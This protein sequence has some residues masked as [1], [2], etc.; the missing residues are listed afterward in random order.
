MN[1]K[2][3]KKYEFI[4]K[5]YLLYI[6]MNLENNQAY[7]AVKENLEFD[8]NKL[9]SELKRKKEALEALNKAKA[10]NRRIPT[11]EYKQ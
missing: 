3:F 5:K 8:I 4:N 2:L 7:K 9:E 1:K 10:D 11:S 6:I